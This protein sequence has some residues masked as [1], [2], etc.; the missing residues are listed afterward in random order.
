L[1]PIAIFDENS[2]AI[3]TCRLE[4][5][6]RERPEIAIRCIPVNA[7]L[8]RGLHCD[9]LVIATNLAGERLESL[10][11]A[12]RHAGV[13]I[14][15]CADDPREAE[16]AKECIE[17]HGLQLAYEGTAS[18]SWYYA[19]GKRIV[20]ICVSSILLIILSPI[21]LLIALLIRLTSLGPALFVQ[22][23]VGRDGVLFRMY[24]FRSMSSRAR[25]YEC[26]PKTS[27]DPRITAIGR[28]L[29]R[30]SL[31]EL[32]QLLNVFLGHMSLVGPRPEMP[33]IVRRY[34][35]R[36]QRRL[37]VTPGITGLWQLS[38]DRAYPIHENLHHDFSYIRR[39][40]LSLDL[41]ILIHTFFFAMRGGV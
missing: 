38:G 5:A 25:P 9:L 21:F 36:Q 20:D 29:R 32:P 26:S 1:R 19:H 24:K 37:E 14:A 30:C 34:N 40:S 23:R 12:A 27:H 8:L 4:M 6:F 18:S 2:E 33:F 28:F 7:D 17:L 31:D 39:R 41:A 10:R 15:H 35:P 22:R 11:S 16:G 3:E 13:R